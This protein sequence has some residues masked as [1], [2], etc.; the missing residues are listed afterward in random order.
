MLTSIYNEPWS[1]YSGSN[2]EGS[3]VPPLPTADDITDDLGVR[4]SMNWLNNE[5]RS[6]VHAAWRDGGLPCCP[7]IE[8]YED[9]ERN[10]CL[11]QPFVGREYPLCSDSIFHSMTDNSDEAVKL[12]EE[13]C[14]SEPQP[15]RMGRRTPDGRKYGQLNRL[16][17]EVRLEV[18]SQAL[19]Q[20]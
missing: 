20:T 9:M 5:L 11:T 12:Y 6:K 8:E 1:F 4:E 2:G 10:M 19:A 14:L 18:P 3:R 15:G 17:R 16:V 13:G 7:T